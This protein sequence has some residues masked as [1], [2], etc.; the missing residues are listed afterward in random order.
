[1]ALLL[2]IL[3]TTRLFLLDWDKRRRRAITTTNHEISAMTVWDETS[4]I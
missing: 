3:S 4:G 1:M 2:A